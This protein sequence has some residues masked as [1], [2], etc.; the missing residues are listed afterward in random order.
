VSPRDPISAHRFALLVILWTLSRYPRSNSHS[1]R[2]STRCAIAAADGVWLR[3]AACATVL[4]V[5]D[6][7]WCTPVHG[8][9]ATSPHVDASSSLSQIGS[10]FTASFHTPSVK[11]SSPLCSLHAIHPCS[12]DASA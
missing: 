7:T 5:K 8:A 1:D 3:I 6:I 10:P 11:R 12:P 2:R 4:S 9:R